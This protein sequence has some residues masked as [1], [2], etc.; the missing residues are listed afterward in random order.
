MAF[1]NQPFQLP[2]F[3]F[4]GCGLSSIIVSTIMPW[5]DPRKFSYIADVGICD[6]RLWFN[7]YCVVGSYLIVWIWV[8]IGIFCCANCIAIGVNG[9]II[10]ASSIVKPDVP[11]KLVNPFWII[12]YI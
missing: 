9:L 1:I 12:F 11:C 10:Y 8:G 2:Y 6:W 4:F 3:F 7:T 5:V